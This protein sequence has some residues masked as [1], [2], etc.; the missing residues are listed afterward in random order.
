M[1][2]FA[3]ELSQD[4]GLTNSWENST[5]CC[6]WE[7]ITCSSDRTVT[8]VFLASKSLQGH[9]SASLGNLT[10]LVC[11]NLSHNSLYGDL[12]L[13]LLSSKSIVILDVSFNLLNGDLQELEKSTIRPF[14][15]TEHIKQLFYRTFSISH[16]GGDEEFGRSQCQQ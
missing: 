12:P 8:D 6:K 9:I 2:Q 11:L 15:G 13:E 4:G 16:M 5:D 3:A 1:L 10:G 14:A 7:G